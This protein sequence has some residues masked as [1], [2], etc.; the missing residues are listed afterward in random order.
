[1]FLLYS[2]SLWEDARQPWNMVLEEQ[3][4]C[5]PWT[6]LY[7]VEHTGEHKGPGH[8]SLT[9]LPFTCLFHSIIYF[10]PQSCSWDT[11]FLHQQWIKK[12]NRVPIQQFVHRIQQLNGYL[13]LLPCLYYSG[14]ATKLTKVVK[15]FG[16][17]YWLATFC[18]WSQ[19][20]GKT[21]M[22]LQDRPCPKHMEASG[23]T[24]THLKGLPSR[25]R[26]W[27]E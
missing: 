14:C 18:N 9:A 24:W 11:A 6:D 7:G 21:S 17:V 4:D 15:P 8:H 10:I 23:C 13:D 3:I 16:A 2:N 1:M 22:S 19:D 25:Q 12:S 20:I 5:K 26:T 27:Q